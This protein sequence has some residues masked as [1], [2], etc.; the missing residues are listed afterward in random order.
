[1]GAKIE[2]ADL[3]KR[4]RPYG[5]SLNRTDG[6]VMFQASVD[7]ISSE[8]SE[9]SL[10]CEASLATHSYLPLRISTLTILVPERNS[11]APFERKLLG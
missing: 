9:L 4:N 8:Y 1:M 5:N 2:L 11:T 6:R 7:V 3:V 10:C